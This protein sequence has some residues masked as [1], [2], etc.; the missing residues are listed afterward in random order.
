MTRLEGIAL[1]A[2]AA[3]LPEP[4][5]EHRFHPERRWRFDHAWP[6]EK[7]A[8]E[9]DG[10]TWTGGRHVT[11]AGYAADLEKLNTAVAMGWRVLRVTPAM[12]ADGRALLWVSEVLRR[13][14]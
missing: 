10:G 8:L 3:G 9:V 1:Q 4:V 2:R 5:A 14:A 7:V 12:V 13:A 6:A 11:G